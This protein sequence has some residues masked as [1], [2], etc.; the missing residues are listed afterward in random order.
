LAV[1]MG[2]HVTNLS[3]IRTWATLLDDMRKDRDA[4]R[5]QAQGRRLPSPGAKMTLWRWLKT[6][7]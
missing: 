7:V 6:T 1:P 2:A 5:D 4:W 3:A